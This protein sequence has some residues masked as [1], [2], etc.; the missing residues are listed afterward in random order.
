MGQKGTHVILQQ[1]VIVDIPPNQVRYFGAT[2]KILLPSAATIAAVIDTILANK[3]ILTDLL[4]KK[5]L[6]STPTAKRRRSN[7]LRIASFA[8]NNPSANLTPFHGTRASCPT[9]HTRRGTLCGEK[10][11]IQTETRAAS[12]LRL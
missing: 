8:S 7:N 3:L 4:R 6:A 1:D 11:R 12:T 10:R 9:F 5:V 2:G